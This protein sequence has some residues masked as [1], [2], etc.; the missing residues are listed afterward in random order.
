MGKTTVT[1]K[2]PKQPTESYTIDCP[3]LQKKIEAMVMDKRY[4]PTSPEQK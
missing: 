1:I 2:R 4:I 3:E